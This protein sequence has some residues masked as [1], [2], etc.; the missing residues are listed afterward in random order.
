MKSIGFIGLGKMGGAMSENLLKHGHSLIVFDIN[1]GAINTISDMGAEGVG[2]PR[3]VAER[4]NI[5][6]LSLPGPEDVKQVVL[7]SEGILEGAQEGS[8]IIDTSTIDP[9]TSQELANIASSKGINM[10]DAPVAGGGPKGARVGKQTV[11]VGGNRDAYEECKDILNILGDT[12]VYAGKNGNGL[13]IKLSF[14]IYGGMCIIAAAEALAFGVKL[15]VKPQLIYEVINTAR[16]GDWILENKCPFPHCNENSPSS[17]NYEPEFP[18]DMAIKDYG[19]VMSC[20][21]TLKMPLLLASL[22]YQMF[23]S[24][25]TSGFGKKDVSA[26]G[27][28]VNQLGGLNE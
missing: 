22:T 25:S 23:E 14:N 27:L 1:P 20:I 13:A 24:A 8:T 28:L 18:I 5:L 7:G 17:R 4:C 2:S 19:L 10:L 9:L 12:V 26:V 16:G 6:I 11:I 15:G 3:E 21:N